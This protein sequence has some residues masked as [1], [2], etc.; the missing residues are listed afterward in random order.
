MIL[1]TTCQWLCNLL[2]KW[3]NLTLFYQINLNYYSKQTALL[4]F[5]SIIP[6]LHFSCFQYF[7]SLFFICS[8]VQIIKIHT[9]NLINPT[10]V[11]VQ[12]SM[13]TKETKIQ[14]YISSC[15]CMDRQPITKA[16]LQHPSQ[17]SESTFP[18][19]LRG[20]RSGYILKSGL[21]SENVYFFL[22]FLVCSV[23]APEIR[24]KTWLENTEICFWD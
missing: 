7:W 13:K 20:F 14:V 21:F 4:H 3:N 18:S 23:V 15:S 16:N 12:A 5:K 2:L 19:E 1:S 10:E 9:D 22:I 17:K 6:L 24:S 8:N 11:S